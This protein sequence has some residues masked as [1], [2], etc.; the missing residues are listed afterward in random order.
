MDVFRISRLFQES[1]ERVV[2]K[3]L[4]NVLQS[5][6]VIAG[7]IRRRDE[8]KEQLNFFP[9]Q[10]FEV[11][12]IRAD[13]NSTYWFVNTGMFCVRDCN[14]A[15]DSGATQFF[16]FEDSLDNVLLFIGFELSRFDQTTDEF[17]N[18]SFFVSRGKL[19]ADR[20]CFDKI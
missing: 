10:T 13:A 20:L 16:A 7:A 17:A 11:D 9:I 12:T 19:G 15:P 6:K 8:H 18:D 3:L 2:L 4:G 1:T 14:T 5:F